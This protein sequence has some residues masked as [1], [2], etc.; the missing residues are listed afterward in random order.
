[1]LDSGLMFVTTE[2]SDCSIESSWQ[3]VS[4]D[5]SVWKLGHIMN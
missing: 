5:G 2:K 1:M 3:G 4:N